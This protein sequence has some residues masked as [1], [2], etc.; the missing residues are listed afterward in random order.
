[1]WHDQD[2]VDMIG[3]RYNPTKLVRGF[4]QCCSTLPMSIGL[5]TLTRI[6]RCRMH[7]SCTLL[8]NALRNSANLRKKA[9]ISDYSMDSFERSVPPCGCGRIY[10]AGGDGV[11]CKEFSWCGELH[12]EAKSPYSSCRCIEHECVPCV[13]SSQTIRSNMFTPWLRPPLLKGQLV[14]TEHSGR[15]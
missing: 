9:W 11:L 8:D 10:D 6:L 14:M 4:G 7:T 5:L 13:T 1:M 15:A 3:M 2:S 12:K